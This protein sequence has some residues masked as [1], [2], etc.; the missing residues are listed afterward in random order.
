MYA[1]L[2]TVGF[3]ALVVE[4][5]G[6]GYGT[7]I[8]AGGVSFGATVVEPQENITATSSDPSANTHYY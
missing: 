8:V 4:T 1:A 6:A 7:G 3:G 5:F 2:G